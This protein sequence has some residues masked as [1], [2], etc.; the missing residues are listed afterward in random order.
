MTRFSGRRPLAVWYAFDR[1]LQEAA[2]AAGHNYWYAYVEEILSRIGVSARPFDLEACADAGALDRVGVL[3]LGNFRSA[4]L[5]ADAAEVLGQWVRAGGILIGFATEGL[6]DLFGIA[7][8]ETLPQAAGPFS[9]NGYF[10]FTSAAVAQDCR[11]PIDPEQRLIILSPLRLIRELEGESVA[12]LF[13]VDAAS[14]EE[15]RRARDAGAPAI[16]HCRLGAGHAFYFAFDVAQTMWTIQQGR[17]VDQDYDGDGYLRR[18]DASVIGRNSCAVPYTDALHFLLASM[19]GRAPVPM[20]HPIPPCEGRVAPALLYFGGD[21]ECQPGVQVPASDFMA[22]RGLPYHMNIMPREGEFA[23][24]A[25][26]QAHIEANGH[27]LAVHY[28]FIDGFELPGGFSREDVL[29]QARLF[30]QVF[31]RDSVCNVNHWVRWCG[32]A[33]PSRW[34][35]EAGNQGDNSFFGWTSPPLN[36]VNLIGFAHGSALPRYMWDDAAHG[37]ERI[38]FLELP[39][40]GYEVG[41]LEDEFAPENLKAGLDLARRYH[42]TLEFFWHPIYIARYPACQRAIDELVRLIGQLPVPPVLM[43]PDRLCHWWRAR[44]GASIEGAQ[45]Q[46]GGVVFEVCCDWAEGYVAKVPTGERQA[47]ECLVDGRAVGFEKALEFGQ[48][49]AFIPLESGRRMVELRW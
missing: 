12:R 28:N 49:W 47:G 20:I 14:R 17:P 48:H 46:A 5:P 32:W 9:I 29:A 25:D 42:L 35:C 31:G 39:I 7:A 41:Y 34:M 26:E 21:D 6:D 43:G 23:L 45:Q 30:R 37:N 2:N 22:A 44:S 16:T 4:D 27:E 10:E 33:E 38:D 19:I 3:F 8:G 11:A 24:N 36:P 15:G 40:T 1:R 13:V 18:T